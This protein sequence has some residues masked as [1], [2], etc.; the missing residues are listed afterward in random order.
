MLE[1]RTDVNSVLKRMVFGLK[2]LCFGIERSM[3][4]KILMETRRSLAAK[5]LAGTKC[6]VEEARSPACR[7]GDVK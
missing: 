6:L 1:V 5:G 3:G 2:L 4:P 7:V